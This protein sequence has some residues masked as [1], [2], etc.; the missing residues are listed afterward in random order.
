MEDSL[1]EL[2]GEIF[3]EH[4]SLVP[5]LIKKEPDGSAVVSG[6]T[7]IRVVKRTLGIELPENGN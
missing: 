7:A 2:V 1:E 5:Q 3:S 6:S 4:V